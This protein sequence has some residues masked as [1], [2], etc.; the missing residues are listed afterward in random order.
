M[1][2]DALVWQPMRPRYCQLKKEG[3]LALKAKL[4]V[5]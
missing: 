3:R 2:Q 5:L 1:Y 4:L